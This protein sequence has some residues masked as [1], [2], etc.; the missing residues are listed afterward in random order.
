MIRR[1]FNHGKTQS[2][3]KRKRCNERFL[4]KYFHKA[5]F[6]CLGHTRSKKTELLK[7]IDICSTEEDIEKV[8]TELSNLGVHF[9]KYA[10]WD[11]Y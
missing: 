2:E 8:L 4:K 3:R 6:E 5:Y 1:Y 10:P 9:Y 11:W 7:Q